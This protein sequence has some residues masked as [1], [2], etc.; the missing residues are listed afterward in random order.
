MVLDGPVDVNE[1]EYDMLIR[2]PGIGPKSARRIVE[3]RKKKRIES[4]R[5]LMALGVRIN[6]ASPYVKIN[7]WYD[8]MLDRWS[9]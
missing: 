7:G 8:T 5:E 9:S 6:R 3:Y 1:A 4:K 2:I